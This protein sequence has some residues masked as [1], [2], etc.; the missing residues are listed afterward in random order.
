[1]NGAATALKVGN[2]RVSEAELALDAATHDAEFY[3]VNIADN[4]LTAPSDG[5]IQYRL[6]NVGEVLPAGG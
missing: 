5:R 6:A 2:E 3:K 4:S 1:L